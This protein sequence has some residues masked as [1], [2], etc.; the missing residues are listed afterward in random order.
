MAI[1]DLGNNS[2]VDTATGIY[3]SKIDGQWVKNEGPTGPA[4]TATVSNSGQYT[5][6]PEF[7]TAGATPKSYT[8]LAWPETT[9]PPG[10]SMS[11][12]NAETNYIDYVKWKRQELENLIARYRA[13]YPQQIKAYRDA[14]TAGL[15]HAKKDMWGGIYKNL[16]QRGLSDSA[17]FLGGG[18]SDLEQWYTGEKNKIADTAQ[19]MET[20]AQSAILQAIGKPDYAGAYNAWTDID[21]RNMEYLTS[22]IGKKNTEGQEITSL[23]PVTNAITTTKA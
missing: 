9:P 22:L 4:A 11:T 18:K 7:A 15:D 12:A 17:S 5:R 2:G 10:K 8:S 14:A 13:A 16:D 19:G 3:Y 20:G 6:N 1:T 21:Q 23:G